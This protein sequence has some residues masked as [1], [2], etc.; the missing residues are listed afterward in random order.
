MELPGIT[1]LMSME[2]GEWGSRPPLAPSRG[3]RHT[4]VCVCGG[5]GR[6][7]GHQG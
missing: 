4:G 7:G 1:K 3:K 6:G 2:W 5:W